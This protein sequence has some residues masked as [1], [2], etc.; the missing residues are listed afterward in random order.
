VTD[1]PIRDVPPEV[2]AGAG[3]RPITEADWVRFAALTA[4]LRDEKIMQAAW[5]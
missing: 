2:P 4:D 1:V 5:Q 3:D